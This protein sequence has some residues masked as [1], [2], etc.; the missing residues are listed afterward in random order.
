MWINNILFIIVL[1]VLSMSWR[2]DFTDSDQKSECLY[3]T[4]TQLQNSLVGMGNKETTVNYNVGF[5]VIALAISQWSWPSD[6]VCEVC[7]K[8]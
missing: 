6:C 5:T 7:N 2:C 4:L 1:F 8:L 3:I